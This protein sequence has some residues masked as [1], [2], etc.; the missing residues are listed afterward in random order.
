MNL[1]VN[2]DPTARIDLSVIRGLDEAD[3]KDLSEKL[4]EKNPIQ[5]TF[6][7]PDITGSV[8]Y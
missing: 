6:Y 3:E 2:A 1:G 4:M 5:K 8:T 7:P